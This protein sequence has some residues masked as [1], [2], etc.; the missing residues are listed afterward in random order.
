MYAKGGREDLA[1]KERAE[2][3]LLEGYL[4]AQVSADE[5][6]EAVRAAA[7]PLDVLSGGEIDLQLLERLP[8]E[9]LRR[10]GLGGNPRYLL[11][12]F[13]YYGWPL[14]LPE[15]IFRLGTRG[16]RAVLAHPERN[17]E[18]QARPERVA[19]L[20]EAGALVQLTAASVDGRL[21]RSSRA[22]AMRLLELDLAHVVASDAHAPSIRQI[23]MTAAADA[24]GDAELARWLTVEVPDA[25]VRREP[26]PERPERA[27]PR[28][29][30]PRLRR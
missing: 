22:A 6:R 16:F 20:V 12:E 27:K 23:G 10:F 24:V 28:L 5:L 1:D 29:R 18:V 8:D 9:E 26:L 30:L 3:A 19:Q 4:P 21:G 14:G 11:L 13:P 25:I 2:A 7:I 15:T 17:A